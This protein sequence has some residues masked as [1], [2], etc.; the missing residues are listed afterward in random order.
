DK[1]QPDPGPVQPPRGERDRPPM[2]DGFPRMGSFP[3]MGGY[4]PPAQGFPRPGT[5]D[6]TSA[7]PV[8]DQKPLMELVVYGYATLYERFPA[9]DAKV[10]GKPKTAKTLGK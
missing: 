7:A 4:R 2:M 10:L 3:P 9:R 5:G 1:T 8:S 6:G